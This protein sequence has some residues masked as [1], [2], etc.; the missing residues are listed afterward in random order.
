MDEVTRM[1]ES[2]PRKM[3]AR[4]EG[5]PPKGTNLARRR[6]AAVMSDGNRHHRV[7]SYQALIQ[8]PSTSMDNSRPNTRSGKLSVGRSSYETVRPKEGRQSFERPR[9]SLETKVVRGLRGSFDNWGPRLQRSTS[10]LGFDDSSIEIHAS[11]G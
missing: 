3:A 6:S 11:K 5:S 10:G 2:S 7:N 4:L 9:S 1:L 8:R